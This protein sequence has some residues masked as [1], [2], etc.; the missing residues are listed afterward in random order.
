MADVYKGLTIQF[1]AETQGLTAALKG[2][3]KQSR[4]ITSELKKVENALKF[5][6]GNTELLRQKQQLLAKEIGTS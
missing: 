5:N 1:G 6:P 3:D 2:I 4:G